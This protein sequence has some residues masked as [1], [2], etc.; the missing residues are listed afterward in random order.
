MSELTTIISCEVCA[1]DIELG[2]NTILNEL[3]ECIDCA[4]EY[5]VVSI[6]PFTIEEAPMEAEDWG[7]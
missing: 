1:A 7:Q 2:P 6:H 5:E 4:T 3:I